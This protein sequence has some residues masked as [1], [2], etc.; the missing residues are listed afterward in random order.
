MIKT[1][2]ANI[3]S[4]TQLR[5]LFAQ[6][7]ETCPAE[8]DEHGRP[9]NDEEWLDV[10]L[11]KRL[12]AKECHILQEFL[13]VLSD[14]P[15]YIDMHFP[16]GIYPN[17]PHKDCEDDGLWDAIITNHDHNVL[18]IVG[19]NDS[20][21]MVCIGKNGKGA[22]GINPSLTTTIEV[23]VNMLQQP[24]GFYLCMQA[25]TAASKLFMDKLGLV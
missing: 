20:C 21:A 22:I 15:G 18:H 8:F 1:S 3:K 17:V 24:E 4:K 12:T 19:A 6:C 25:S 5:K 2:N 13:N 7:L 16:N 14:E 9:C 23:D 11:Q 10:Q